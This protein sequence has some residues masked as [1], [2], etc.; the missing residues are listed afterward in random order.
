MTT[1]LPN[2]TEPAAEN[3]AELL[4]LSET[5]DL[6]ESLAAVLR[7]DLE[8]LDLSERPLV[9]VHPPLRDGG[10]WP[11][12]AGVLVAIRS[13]R[14]GAA[15]GWLRLGSPPPDAAEALTMVERLAD[16]LGRTAAHEREARQR[17]A[18]LTT[19]YNT[20][21]MLAEARDLNSVLTRTVRLVSDVMGVKGASIRLID[22]DRDELRF[23]AVHGLSQAYL[24][25]APLRLSRAAIDLAAIRN[26][27]E[28]VLDLRG[29]QRV[30]FPDV[31]EAEGIIS[32]LSV[33]MRYRGQVIGVLR[34]YTGEPRR[35]SEDEID[36]IGAV[37]SQAAA[38]IVNARLAE[39]SA[40]ADA[41]EK[42]VIVA[43][44]VQQRMIPPFPPKCR[45][46]E[47]ASAYTPCY[48]LA[49][50]LCDFIVLPEERIGV[51]IADV[52][53]KGVPASLIMATARAYLR[54]SSEYLDDLPRTLE[55]LNAMLY[56]DNRPGEFVSMFYGIFDG[57]RKTLDY[58][59]AGHAP[60]LLKRGG[61]VRQLEGGDA[62]LGVIPDATYGK[63]RLDLQEE[64]SLL[65]Y[66]DGLDEARNFKDE[67]Y[68]Q[69]RVRQSFGQPA[70]SAEMI[71]QN[72][73]WDMHRFVGLQRRTDDVTVIAVRVLG[74]GS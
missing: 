10:S 59:L 47:F 58:V 48:E 3:L 17:Q 33:P 18:E 39:E 2:L 74:S 28:Q 9:A 41:L 13:Q 53:G 64:D 67:L 52:A 36:L 20:S 25:S 71:V 66:T 70:P 16:L 8:L 5:R 4:D 73:I 68:G 43:A 54:A 12:E 26:G 62:V 11:Q 57:G 60:P 63:R 38:A 22:E 55:G 50:D 61:E 56:R 32:V 6:L 46:L 7:V 19:I 15:L 42:Q 69:E 1:T 51:V 23:V 44:D 45:S 29:D 37:A 30:Q 27:H 21:M 31:L 35:F 65:L 49:G 72:V 24:T 34:A 40:Q 14:G